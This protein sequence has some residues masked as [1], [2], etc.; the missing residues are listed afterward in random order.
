MI[1]SLKVRLY[2]QVLTDL[3]RS[4]S[5]L[6]A[7]NAV[8]KLSFYQRFIYPGLA[9]ID[10]RLWTLLRPLQLVDTSSRL[11]TSHRSASL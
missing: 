5:T 6:A 1:K 7:F 4:F 9:D 2:N 3:H 10:Q 8:Q 11:L